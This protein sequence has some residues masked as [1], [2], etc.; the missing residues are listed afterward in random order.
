MSAAIT[1]GIQRGR[2]F[3]KGRSGNPA[4]KPRGARHYTTRLAEAMLDGEAQALTRKAIELALSGDTFAL[5][6]CLERILPPRRERNVMLSLP[7]LRSPRDAGEVS[8]AILDA[9]SKGKISLSEAAE[10]ARLVS[11]HVATLESSERYDRGLAL[12][13]AI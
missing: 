8:A 3:T 10:L 7:D 6:L 9:A 13:R 4:G 12:M 11:A 5:K 1:A 2:P